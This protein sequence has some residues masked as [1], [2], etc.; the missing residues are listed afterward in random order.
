MTQFPRASAKAPYNEIAGHLIS[1]ISPFHFN[2][3]LAA[4]FRSVFA[5]DTNI[6]RDLLPSPI[7]SEKC[8]RRKIWLSSLFDVERRTFASRHYALAKTSATKYTNQSPG[9][10]GLEIFGQLRPRGWNLCAHADANIREG[11]LFECSRR[12]LLRM[13]KY[14]FSLSLSLGASTTHA[15]TSKPTDLNEH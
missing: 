13:Y 9:V 7:R 2:Y 10:V 12:R 6:L 8:V 5:D 3:Q 14:W 1:D 4:G 15:L 11:A